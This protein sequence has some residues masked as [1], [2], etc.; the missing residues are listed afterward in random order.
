[1]NKELNLLHK[2]I[3][4]CKKCSLW[5]TRTSAVPGEGSS[6]AKIMFIGLSPGATE[7]K[8]GKPFVGR[9]GKLLDELLN[10]IKLRRKDVF[11]TS[12]LRCHPP[13][14]RLPKAK[15]VAACLPY[16]QKYIEIINPRIIVLLGN[17]AIKTVLGKMNGINKIHGKTMRRDGKTYFLT[18]HPAAGIRATRT[19]IKLQQDFEKLKNLL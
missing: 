19:K 10:S 11:I 3:R 4:A 9:A 1:M 16:L 14:N 6:N 18:F 13:K 2:K 5:K 17:V 12:V 7:D 8:T 15:E